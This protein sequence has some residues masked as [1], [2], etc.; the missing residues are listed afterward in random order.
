MKNN[1]HIYRNLAKNKMR[2]WQFWPR[3]PSIVKMKLDQ[4]LWSVKSKLIEYTVIRLKRNST[5]TVNTKSRNLQVIFFLVSSPWQ[6][7][8][9]Y[10][11]QNFKLWYIKY[12]KNVTTTA[13]NAMISRQKYFTKLYF[14]PV[15]CSSGSEPYF[16][17]NS[18]H[19]ISWSRG[20]FGLLR[21]KADKW[22]T[23]LAKL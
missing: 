15:A 21:I 14:S 17:T 12:T 1:I 11:K 20:L 10:R 22:S 7:V 6:T 4:L 18:V 19:L 13:T 23:F 9:Q 8:L 3:K 16:I 5:G 2:K